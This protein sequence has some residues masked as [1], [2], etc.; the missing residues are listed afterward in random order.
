M[1]GPHQ[2]SSYSTTVEL[3]PALSVVNLKSLYDKTEYCSYGVKLSYP[4]R[5]YI[6][7]EGEYSHF[8]NASG[9][10]AHS[11]ALM[12]LRGGI[13][14]RKVGA[15]LKLLPGMIRVVE[16]PYPYPPPFHKFVLSVGGV[17]EAHVDPRVYI[18]ID[19]GYLIMWL[20]DTNF[21]FGTPRR[22]GTS[23]YYHWSIG[24]GVRF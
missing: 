8:V 1:P 18:R 9:D 4:W 7:I 20:G 6:L 23:K 17:V 22:P 3:G 12:G 16:T 15:F 13:R 21:Y 2:P 24:L 11:L 5:D 14:K 10:H 19:Q